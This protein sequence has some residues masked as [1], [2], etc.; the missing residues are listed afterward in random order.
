MQV[1]LHKVDEVCDYIQFLE[2]EKCIN[3]LIR[4]QMEKNTDVTGTV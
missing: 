2:S 4:F 1:H 3:S